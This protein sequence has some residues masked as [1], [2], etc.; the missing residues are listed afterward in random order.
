M[1]V[2]SN[3][4]I[5]WRSG[6]AVVRL[7]GAYVAVGDGGRRWKCASVFQNKTGEGLN[8]PSPPSPHSHTNP[9]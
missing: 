7:M 3:V 9:R 1:S 4:L 2:L 8:P 5:L 6:L